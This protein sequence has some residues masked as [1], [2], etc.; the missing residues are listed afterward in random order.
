MSELQHRRVGDT[1]RTAQGRGTGSSDLRPQPRP[2][3]NWRPRGRAR[4]QPRRRGPCRG[5]RR[6]FVVV[7]YGGERGRRSFPTPTWPS[8]GSWCTPSRRYSWADS[9]QPTRWPIRCMPIMNKLRAFLLRPFVRDVIAG[10]HSTVDGQCARRPRNASAGTPRAVM[11]LAHRHLPRELREG[12]STSAS[13]KV[14]FNASPE[15]AREPHT[16]ASSPE[17]A[18]PSPVLL[19]GHGSAVATRVGTARPDSGLASVIAGCEPRRALPAEVAGSQ[20]RT[21]AA[22][23]RWRRARRAMARISRARP[24]IA[25]GSGCVRMVNGCA[26]SPLSTRHTAASYTPR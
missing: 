11:T 24:G 23:C 8:L 3:N 7:R 4:A 22:W 10:G 18:A 13:S 15:D 20:R 25:R 14:F 12:M 16:I 6:V 2:C 19:R 1:T 17:P 9:P 26:S 5:D 21:A